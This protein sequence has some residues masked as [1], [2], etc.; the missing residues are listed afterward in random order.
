M[1]STISTEQLNGGEQ[2]LNQ[3]LAVVG[4]NPPLNVKISEYFD[5][6]KVKKGTNPS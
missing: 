1:T 4:F 2:H 6:F 5:Q 3:R